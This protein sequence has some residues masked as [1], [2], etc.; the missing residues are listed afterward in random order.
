MYYAAGCSQFRGC[1]RLYISFVYLRPLTEQ[2]SQHDDNSLTT[3]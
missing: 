1:E 3:S 2:A